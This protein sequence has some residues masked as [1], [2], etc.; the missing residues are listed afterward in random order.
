MQRAILKSGE[1][2]RNLQHFLRLISYY[3]KNVPAVI[4]DGIYSEQTKLSVKAF[5]KEFGLNTT[6]EVNPT[7]WEKIISIYNDL[8]S[9]NNS[10]V[11]AN[12]FPSYKTQYI[13]GE[14]N[15]CLFTIQAMLYAITLVIKNIGSLDITGILDA[16]TVFVVK[17]IQRL[18]NIPEN[19]SI[20]CITWKKISQLYSL[21]ITSSVNEKTPKSTFNS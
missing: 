21:V 3:Y 4:P 1:P 18:S 14:K 19:G 7:T 5:Q 15:H 9:I 20:D 6:G 12:I 8:E 11:L 16:K 13:P 17:N 2:I 10:P